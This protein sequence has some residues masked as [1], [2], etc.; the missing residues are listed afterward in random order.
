[1][2]D[3]ESAKDI[4]AQKVIMWKQHNGLNQKWRI[5]YTD[6][7]D[8]AKTGLNKDFGFYV[9]KP[10]YIRSRLPSKRMVECVGRDAYQM[11]WRSGNTGQQWIFDPVTKT[12]K[13]NKQK[14]LSLMI[15][16]QRGG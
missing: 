9:N 11:R 15:T 6:T 14:N 4:E 10:F 5:V 3:V 13:N 8:V 7:V 16:N 1:V 12:I 2:F